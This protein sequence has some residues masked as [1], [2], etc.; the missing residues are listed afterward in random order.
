MTKELANKLWRYEEGALYWKIAGYCRPLI[1]PAG[2][3]DTHGYVK[4]EHKGKR[5]YR[6]R[7]VY[8]MHKG[9]WPYPQCDHRNRIRDD[10]RIE[11]LREVPHSI[12]CRNS[13]VR[14]IS[15]TG[16]KYISDYKYQKSYRFRILSSR[17][18]N[19]KEYYLV[20]KYFSYRKYSKELALKQAIEYKK[21]WFIDNQDIANRYFLEPD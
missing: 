14:K 12:N 9:K 6:S 10:D 19:Q 4:I 11:N 1:K 17:A 20:S 18:C 2:Y 13:S 5:Y 7:L 16:I 3:K 21:Q 8:L 15:T